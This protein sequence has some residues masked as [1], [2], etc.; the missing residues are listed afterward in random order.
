MPTVT[1][2][3]HGNWAAHAHIEK[4]HAHHERDAMH[5]LYPVRARLVDAAKNRGHK[6]PTFLVPHIT[7]DQ[8]LALNA[9]PYEIVDEPGNILMN[10]GI[11]RLGSLLIGGG[12]QAYDATHTAIGAGDT[13]T[14]AAASQTDLAA[15]VNAANRWVQLVD[16]TPAFASQVL[17]CV[18]TFATGNGNFA[19]A[20]WAIGQNT[21]SAAAAITAP[22]LNRKVA[23][24]GT[25]TS[26]A[27]WAFTTTIT[28]S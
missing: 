14:A 3:E 11:A 5:Q 8:M 15:T 23:A 21:S 24:L 20:E 4:F 18:A 10:A 19:W 1:A 26:A 27:A 28:I 17:T 7:G 9:D 6:L 13:N 25:K 12:G 16:S 22:M 2:T